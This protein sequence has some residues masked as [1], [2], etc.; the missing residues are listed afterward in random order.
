[1]PF[2]IITGRDEGFFPVMDENGVALEFET[3]DEAIEYK[4]KEDAF[5][6]WKIIEVD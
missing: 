6:N 2:I 5:G 3:E 4:T 1:M